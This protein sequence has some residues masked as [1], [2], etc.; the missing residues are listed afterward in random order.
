MR[1]DGSASGNVRE[2]CVVEGR[3]FG[4][5]FRERWSIVFQEVPDHVLEG[6]VHVDWVPDWLESD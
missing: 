4:V 5:I 3:G 1:A 2:L 6:P